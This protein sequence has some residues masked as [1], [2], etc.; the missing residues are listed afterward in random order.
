MN[1]SVS[2]DVHKILFINVHDI[3]LDLHIHLLLYLFFFLNTAIKL[4]DMLLTTNELLGTK[5]FGSVIN[6]SVTKF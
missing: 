3:I 4:D 1:L 6:M 2:K 5:V